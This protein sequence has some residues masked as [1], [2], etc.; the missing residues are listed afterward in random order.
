MVVDAIVVL[1]NPVQEASLTEIVDSAT[2]MAG[3]LDTV[4][5]AAAGERDENEG[6]RSGQ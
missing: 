4:G 1:A 3:K 2:A 6:A 5:V